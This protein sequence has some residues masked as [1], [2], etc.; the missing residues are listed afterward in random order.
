MKNNKKKIVKVKKVNAPKKTPTEALKTV[1]CPVCGKKALTFVGGDMKSVWCQHC[2]WHLNSYHYTDEEALKV[3]LNI[4]KTV[5]PNSKPVNECGLDLV[6]PKCGQKHLVVKGAY[7]VGVLTD[8][9]VACEN[10]DWVQPDAGKHKRRVDAVEACV[11]FIKKSASLPKFYWKAAFVTPENR[12]CLIFFETQEDISKLSKE[13][14]VAMCRN[15]ALE[16]FRHRFLEPQ[17]EVF[18]TTIK[19]CYF[20]HIKPIAQSEYLDETGN[21]RFIGYIKNYL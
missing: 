6:C 17:V 7:E 18:T 2:H 12:W 19:E 11:L 20:S 15:L 4:N 13:K 9:F 14:V 3:L 16:R 5:R 1:A 21:A 10:C 8:F